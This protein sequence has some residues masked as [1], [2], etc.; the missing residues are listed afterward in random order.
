MQYAPQLFS[1]INLDASF[2]SMTIQKGHG[3]LGLLRQFLFL[4]FCWN[5]LAMTGWFFCIKVS[6]LRREFRGFGIERGFVLSSAANHN[7]LRYLRA[8]VLIV[9]PFVFTAS[10][11]P[12]LP[13][14]REREM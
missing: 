8:S 13:K 6:L 2:V 9:F 12:A 10:T 7:N 1:S 3:G 5:Y 11:H 4:F 14:P